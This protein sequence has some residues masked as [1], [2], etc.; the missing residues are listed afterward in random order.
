MR[1]GAFP[2]GG[3]LTYANRAG[4]AAVVAAPQGSPAAS[5]LALVLK[6]GPD[7]GLF[8]VLLNGRLALAGVDGFAAEVDWAREVGVPLGAPALAPWVVA[9][10][11]RGEASADATDSYVQ[12]V[13][14]RV[15]LVGGEAERGRPGGQR[16]R[17]VAL[18][19]TARAARPA[20]AA[21]RAAQAPRA[22][23]FVSAAPLSAGP[24]TT[25][26]PQ[27]PAGAWAL[28]LERAAQAG[29]HRRQRC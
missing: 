24:H 8:D 5:A 18:A 20:S 6:F 14:L 19:A 3:S 27:E 26:D 11:A 2:P 10:V 28:R 15:K 17:S 16:R 1:G 22:S 9:V 29:R 21:T 7:C 23:F 25:D 12:V 4:A 13:G